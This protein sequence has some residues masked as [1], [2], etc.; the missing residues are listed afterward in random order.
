MGG[1]D[2]MKLLHSTLALVSLLGVF[3][4]GA[5]TAKAEN[6]PARPVKIIV[7]YPPGG[8]A[9]VLARVI[10]Q[11]LS[12]GLGGRFYVENLAGAS[13]TIG[14]G[15]GASA[16]ADGY[17]LVEVNP[18]FIVQ[19]LIKTKVPYDLFKGFAPII[20]AASAPEMISVNP[21][22]SAKTFKEFIELLK[23]HPGQ[24]Q[25][26]TPGVGTPPHLYG[27]MIYHITYGL[28]VIHVPFPG[29]APAVNS[30]VA[31]HTSILNMTSS[32]QAPYVKAGT[33][34]GI[35]VLSSKQSASLPDVPTLAESG[36]QGQET[37]FFLG[38]V[39]PAGTP[40]AIVALLNR[41]IAKVLILEDVKQRLETL[42]YDPMG[43]SPEDFANK[44]R[45]DFDGWRK[46]VSAAQIK[47]D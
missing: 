10:A 14:T 32:A 46:V 31:G 11:K 45:K 21:A 6:Y 27:E 12:E 16:P 7:P 19:P 24:Y 13:G 4:V 3:A 40:S 29:A 25:F 42:G 5:P 33:L 38:F 1:E 43:G 17:T 26:A 9:D 41:Q 37:D 22:V 23:V 44:I 39:A 36:L 18:D 8:P 30:T 47:I 2:D 20:A 28:D 34:R 35:A 15:A